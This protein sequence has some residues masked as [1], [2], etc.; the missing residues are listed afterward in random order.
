MSKYIT[1]SGV[2]FTTDSADA[3]A[4]LGGVPVAEAPV[5]PAPSTTDDKPAAK[6]AVKRASR[7]RKTSD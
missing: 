3:V 6:P 1:P 4:A 5:K 2:V 7:A